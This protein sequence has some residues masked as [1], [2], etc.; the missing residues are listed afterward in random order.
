M[1]RKTRTKGSRM[2]GSSSHGWGHKKKH[3]G[4][5]HRGGVG[6]SGTGARGDQKKSALLTKSKSFLN[7][8]SAKKCIKVSKIKH[9]YKHFG[10]VGFKSIHKKK[11]NTLSICY[12]ENNF[13]KMVKNGSIVEKEGSFVFDALNFGIDKLLGNCKNFTKKLKVVC[14]D[15]SEAAKMRIEEAGGEVVCE[16]FNE[17]SE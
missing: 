4:A 3:R 13:D 6:F 16:K 14:D 12:I 10:K 9:S 2:R 8:L 15:I 5:G 1:F 7:V 17:V 11:I